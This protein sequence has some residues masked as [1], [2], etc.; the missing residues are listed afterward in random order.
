MKTRFIISL[1]FTTMAFASTI[2]ET[3]KVLPAP[4]ECYETVPLK[5]T[6]KLGMRGQNVMLEGTIEGITAQA[7][8]ANPNFHLEPKLG[9]RAE[10]SQP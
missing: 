3:M 1:F 7:R 4:I 10:A 8:E 6:G 5:W 9:K 2:P